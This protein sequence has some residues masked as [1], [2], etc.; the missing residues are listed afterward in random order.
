MNSIPVKLTNYVSNMAS[1]D[2]TTAGNDKVSGS[3]VAEQNDL[4]VNTL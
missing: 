3:N 4:T 1:L 2:I